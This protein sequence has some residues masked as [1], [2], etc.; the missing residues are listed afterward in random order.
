[1]KL[2]LQRKGLVAT[3]F[4]I[5][6]A[7]LLMMAWSVKGTGGSA[8]PSS[9]ELSAGHVLPITNQPLTAAQLVINEVDYDQPGVD[10]AEFVEIKNN[11]S[12]AVDLAAYRLELVDGQDTS[13]YD[14]IDLPASLLNPG[15]YFV[16]CSNFATVANCD[17][18]LI[19]AIQNGA[20]DA[21]ALWFGDQLVD[22]VSYEGDTAPPYTE[23]SG[24]GLED[25]GV[26]DRSI[27]RFPDG[28]DTNQNNVD[29][30]T[31][32]ITPGAANSSQTHDCGVVL[33]PTIVVTLTAVPLT[34]TAP[35]GPVTFTLHIVNDGP[36]TV[37]LSTLDDDVW[38]DLNGRGTCLTPQAVG[39]SGM[40]SCDYGGIVS[41][42]AGQA[43]AHTAVAGGSG[44]ND[45]SVSGSDT[46]VVTIAAPIG[47]QD[48]GLYLPIVLKP[49]PLGEPNNHCHEAYPLALNQPENFLAE[50][51]DDWYVLALS[52][53][54]TLRVELANF[55][56]A[57]AQ[58]SI[59]SGGCDNLVRIGYD[60]GFEP[61]RII[62]LGSQPAGA[63][64]IW[65][66]NA[67]PLNT[68][69]FYTLTGHTTNP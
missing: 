62:D 7:L 26:G 57:A 66:R 36:I 52:S 32:C 1:M 53:A 61:N 69:D 24:V 10:S 3:V 42:Q 13:I 18:E 51:L 63:Y 67:G 37:T 6:A 33:T 60:G 34:V 46:A 43:V 12:I 28:I 20:P 15:D 64:F 41:G 27:S 11:D 59:F 22:T 40:Y 58:L 14:A 56:P 23:G 9:N 19:S 54:N 5:N 31:R 55:V 50:D 4:S 68:T 49:R 65:L 44:Q 2:G 25:D 45:M 35:G 30:S 8:V 21:V 48:S 38:G 29:F 47:P 17:A 16:I 39:L